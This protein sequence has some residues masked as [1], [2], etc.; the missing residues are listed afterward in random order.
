M[1]T[2]AT[3]WSGAKALLQLLKHMRNTKSTRTTNTRARVGHAGHS[4]LHKT[5]DKILQHHK[6]QQH[7]STSE[8]DCSK[9]YKV[10]ASPARGGRG[11]RSRRARSQRWLYCWG[12]RR[13]RWP[14]ILLHR[15]LLL[16]CSRHAHSL[17]TAHLRKVCS[18]SVTQHWDMGAHVLIAQRA[19]G[20]GS[21]WHARLGRGQDL[22]STSCTARASTAAHGHGYL[23]HQERRTGSKPLAGFPTR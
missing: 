6:L 7:A 17:D 19:K 4:T 16:L 18:S 15:D 20:G 2:R 9:S 23:E 8:I 11:G 3:R 21:A 12:W 13:C 10:R 5:R 14:R 1:T 22:H